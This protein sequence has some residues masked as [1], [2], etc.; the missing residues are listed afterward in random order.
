MYLFTSSLFGGLVKLNC[1]RPSGQNTQL[2]QN[3][4]KQQ[5]I[6]ENGQPIDILTWRF[7]QH[8]LNLIMFTVILKNFNLDF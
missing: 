2:K 5:Q 1:G 8:P 4:H 7:L 6:G 3:R